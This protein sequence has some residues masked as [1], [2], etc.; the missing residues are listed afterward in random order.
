MQICTACIAASGTATLETAL[1]NVPTLLVYKVAAL[2]YG[3]GKL[4]VNIKDIGLPNIV[5]KRR[6]I[7][8]LLQG[9]VTPQNIERELGRILDIPS[10]YKQMK[11]DLTQVKLDLG[12]PGAVQRVA[13][14]IA[15]VAMKEA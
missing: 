11:A 15:S 6:V 12:A 13:D 14:V 9:E 3:I 5:A 10:V 4:L 8:E 2:T 7:P 1:M